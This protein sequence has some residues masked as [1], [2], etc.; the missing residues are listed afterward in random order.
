[1]RVVT[2][3]NKCVRP[4]SLPIPSLLGRPH[5]HHDLPARPVR[6]A[7]LVRLLDLG[8]RNHALDDWLNRAAIDQI[9]EDRELFAA[10]LLD[11]VLRDDALFEE[12]PDMELDHEEAK[13]E[14]AE[15]AA[16]ALD[17]AR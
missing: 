15:D 13:R 10:A 17:V 11:D 6:L 2:R 5:P 16:V 4:R 3:A 1:M 7:Q 8:K 14:H 9:G 12:R